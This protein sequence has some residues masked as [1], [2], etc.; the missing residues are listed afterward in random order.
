MMPG[1]AAL[2][3]VT[4]DSFKYVNNNFSIGRG[5]F[6]EVKLVEKDG[7]RYAMKQLIKEEITRVSI[8]L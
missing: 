2:G 3:G 7:K 5:T 1:S 6:G 4:L 8:K